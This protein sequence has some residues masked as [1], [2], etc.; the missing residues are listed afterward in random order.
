MNPLSDP[1]LPVPIEKETGTT[2]PSSMRQQILME[3]KRLF[4]DRGFAAVSI[5]DII[6]GVGVTKPTL[7]HYFKDKEALYA[8]V[9]L[10]VMAH[11][12]KF[13]QND[14][15]KSVSIRGYLAALAAGY[16]EHS[17]TSLAT[18]LRDAGKHLNPD[19]YKKPRKTSSNYFSIL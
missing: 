16:L 13:I 12:S 10:A 15:Q 19:N 17:P 2:P 8:E 14:R 9:L 18:L 5:N 3:A 1:S 11:G 7:Y 6:E 4:R